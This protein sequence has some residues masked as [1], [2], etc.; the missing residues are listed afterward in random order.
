MENSYRLYFDAMPCYL[1]V[2]DRDFR[3]IDANQRFREDFGDFEGR[4]CYQVY[5]RRSEKC[6]VCPVEQVFRDGHSHRSEE[7]VSCLDG[8]E[9]SVLVEATPIRDQN[10]QITAVIEM[11]TDITQIKNLERQL[12]RSQRRY[13]LLFDEVPC[14]ISIQDS[15][16]H[17]VEAN[18]AF[19]EA[20]G[21]C[22]G[23][24][25]Y[26]VYKHRTEPCIPCPVQETFEDGESHTREEVV[27]SLD[28]KQI[29][30]LVTAAPIRNGRGQII[31]VME[32]SADI[33]QVR[34]L[35]D[36][37]TS[38]GLLIGS[39]SHGLKG[40]L[41]G[42]AGG[43]Y[44][45]DTGFKKNDQERIHK[46]WDTV[47]RNV[48]R[49]RSMVSDILYYA[50]ER[51]PTWETISAVEL[52]TEVCSL[53][54]SRAGEDGIKLTSELDQTAGDFEADP[55]AVRS[56]LVNLLENSLDACRL[57]D[58]KPDHEV[59]L[60]LTGTPS[61]VQYKVQDNGLGMDRETRDKAFS[62]FFSSK[63]MEGTGLGLF[64]ADRIAR[65]HGG[66]IELKSEAGVGTQFIVQL[67]RKRPP[68]EPKDFHTDN[69]ETRD[70]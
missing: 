41:N 42:L 21:S 43:M 19:Q 26:E 15:E 1:T 35:E 67:P 34:E 63:G 46:G 53:M 24:K 16:L 48:A 38:L 62:L 11:S 6:E 66:A 25:C 44:L 39:V 28:G 45:V 51:E 49:I 37:L 32:M 23:R 68:Q 10:G 22:M 58:K 52:G 59:T 2:Q 8:K 61:H 20:F 65:A 69:E 4:F 3:I 57:D 36:Q 56:L 12:R 47:Q 60:R 18:R 54:Y 13:H 17:I 9:V 30:V 29:N 27:K 70:G 5:K 50:K 64:V 33:T 31:R 55:Q 7:Q 40:M 14:Y